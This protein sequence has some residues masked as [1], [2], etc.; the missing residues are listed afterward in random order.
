MTP[1]ATSTPGVITLTAPTSP[2]SLPFH[3]EH[4]K[5]VQQR[6]GHGGSVTGGL[7]LFGEIAQK[8]KTGGVC[9][10]FQEKHTPLRKT[11]GNAKP[12]GGHVHRMSTRQ[13]LALR[14]PTEDVKSA[15]C[16]TLVKK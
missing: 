15:R 5:L 11:H 7:S 13:L 8:H 9:S 16:A 12:A 3:A 10:A 2:I 14:K 4:A 6:V 1:Y